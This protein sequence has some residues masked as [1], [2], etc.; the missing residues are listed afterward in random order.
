MATPNAKSWLTVEADSDFSL[1]NIPFGIFSTPT[2]L[3]RVASRV[4][5]YVIDLATLAELGY[6]NSVH[7][8]EDKSVF[9]ESC[10]NGFIFQ[11]PR[12]WKAVR[13]RV[14]ELF[15][16][17]N[18][19]LV[20]NADHLREIVFHYIDV[21][22]HM[23]IRVGDYTDF[24]SSIE[25][26][27]NVGKMFRDPEN[28]LLPNWRHL[29]VAYHGRSSSIVVS[30]AEIPR[31]MGQSLPKDEQ[32]PVFGP[33]KSLD[34]EL[35][36]AFVVGTDTRLGQRLKAETAEEAIF[37]MMIFN[38]LSARDIQKWE[39][40][41]LGPFLGKS[42]GS[43]VSP[44]VVTLDALEPFRTQGPAQQ[45]EPLP[46]LRT[47][48]PRN[49][50]I[51]LEVW[52]QPEETPATKV[53]H[54]NTKH[55]Y[56]NMAQQLAHHT[57]NGCNLRVGDLC[58]SGTIS[59]PTPDSFGSLLELTWGGQKPIAMQDGSQRRFLEDN[60]TVVMRAYAQK[61]GLRVGFGDCAVKILP[62]ES[63][64]FLS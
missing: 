40:V 20:G 43:V 56:W 34:F 59:G 31:P 52:L 64:E 41:P 13:A 6:F 63:D 44:W 37:G 61:D 9:N 15:S 32:Q 46:Y 57:S 47:S 10:L 1:Q 39:Y 11:G 35:E 38:D 26:A 24:Y 12:A 23:P 55:L 51:E 29:P 50:D 25:H 5:D 21:E 58:A 22:M 53:C 62:A 18:E 49:F 33:S 3:P 27:T 4:G 7:E 17:G 16:H 19:E 14:A 60:D 54:S 28:A 48:G 30:G 42:F 2:S 36:M 45:P 8:L